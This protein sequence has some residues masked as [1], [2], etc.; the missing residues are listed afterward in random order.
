MLFKRPDDKSIKSRKVLKLKVIFLLFVIAFFC[1]YCYIEVT[2]YILSEN[3]VFYLFC[4]KT[5]LMLMN[6]VINIIEIEFFGLFMS[7]LPS[8]CLV[9]QV[10]HYACK[11]I[12][13]GGIMSRCDCFE[14]NKYFHF[15]NFYVNF[16]VYLTDTLQMETCLYG[17]NEV[18]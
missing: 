3:S 13:N 12:V 9:G 17:Q 2:V 18:M 5:S 11:I 14:V 1:V 10:T 15:K 7:D 8:Y 6:I 16:N 4:N